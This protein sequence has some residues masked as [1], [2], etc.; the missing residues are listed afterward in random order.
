MFW[1]TAEYRINM[2]P[3]ILLIVGTVALIAFLIWRR[4]QDPIKKQFK[5][6]KVVEHTPLGVKVNS[7]KGFALL[8]AIDD[9]FR[10][11]QETL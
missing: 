11:M 2:L 10:A 8:T 3:I 7:E 9:E 4:G 5:A 1:R 6:L